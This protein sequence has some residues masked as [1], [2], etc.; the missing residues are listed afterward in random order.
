MGMAIFG[1]TVREFATMHAAMETLFALMNGDSVLQ[2]L[3]VRLHPPPDPLQPRPV[4]TAD[5]ERSS[6]STSV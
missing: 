5:S 4:A 3:Q 2:V 1:A 6:R